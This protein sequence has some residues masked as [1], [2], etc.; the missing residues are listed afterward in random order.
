MC[1]APPIPFLFSS[2]FL[3]LLCSFLI[4]FGSTFARAIANV[5]MRTENKYSSALFCSIPECFSI[6][7]GVNQKNHEIC[8]LLSFG[9]AGFILQQTR[10]IWNCPVPWNKKK[11]EEFVSDNERMKLIKSET[12]IVYLALISFLC[13]FAL[14]ILPCLAELS[15]IAAFRE[16]KMSGLF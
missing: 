7:E 16:K 3:L 10:P 9:D 6:N 5:K 15:K 1:W 8:A 11:Q 2:S 12:L 13:S 4:L 14:S